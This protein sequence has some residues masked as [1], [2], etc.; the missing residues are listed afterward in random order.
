MKRF[1]PVGALSSEK[2]FTLIEIMVVVIILTILAVFLVPNVLDRPHQARVAKA[3]TDIRAIETALGLYKLDN[4]SFPSTEQGLAALVTKPTTGNIP[5]NW[6]EGGYL[7]SMPKD[8]WGNEYV[9]VCPGVNGDFDLKSYG[10]DGA[11]GGEGKDADIE[12]WNLDNDQQ[13]K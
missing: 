9:Y 12:N 7:K 5:S 4:G 13:K 1:I 11:D 10:A 2:G 6:K 8:P 3:K